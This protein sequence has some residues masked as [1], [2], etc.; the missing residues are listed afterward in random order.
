VGPERSLRAS[1]SRTFPCPSEL[2]VQVEDV[3]VDARG[4][5]YMTREEQW[6]VHR[7]LGRFGESVQQ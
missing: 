4:Y 6:S 7:A 3:L 1:V 2:V 5:I